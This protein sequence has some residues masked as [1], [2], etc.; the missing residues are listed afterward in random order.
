MKALGV[1]WKPA[2]LFVSRFNVAVWDFIAVANGVRA[3]YV[4]RKF[5][6]E[7]VLTFLTKSNH[8]IE[9]VARIEGKQKEANYSKFTCET[10]ILGAIDF[11][12][13][14]VLKVPNIHWL[15]IPTTTMK[16]E[17]IF[18]AISLWFLRSRHRRIQNE[19]DE[20]AMT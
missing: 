14:F 4:P 3:F 16:I 2:K 11:V 19:W 6:A 10:V 9:G 13:L 1:F 8:G 7:D 15:D 5:T 18:G 17:I 20:N 12:H